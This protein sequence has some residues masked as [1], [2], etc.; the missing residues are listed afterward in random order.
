VSPARCRRSGLFR[1]GVLFAS[2]FAREKKIVGNRNLFF[3]GSLVT[4]FGWSGPRG[5]VALLGDARGADGQGKVTA[6]P[7]RARSEMREPGRARASPLVA[8][9]EEIS[10]VK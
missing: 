7:A 10:M 8:S 2:C 4:G 1:R 9:Q 5:R 6:G 3:R